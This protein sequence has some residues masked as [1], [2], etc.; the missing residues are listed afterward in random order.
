MHYLG[1]HAFSHANN[2]RTITT[3]GAS[4]ETGHESYNYITIFKHDLSFV[5]INISKY[6]YYNPIIQVNLGLCMRACL[7]GI[8][9]M[10]QLLSRLSKVRIVTMTLSCMHPY[11]LWLH[12]QLYELE[13]SAQEITYPAHKT[14]TVNGER[15]ERWVV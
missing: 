1:N 6:Y 13:I 4:P 15:K 14:M 8:L 7:R 11:I 9:P 5:P 3:F 2:I 12:Q 10:R